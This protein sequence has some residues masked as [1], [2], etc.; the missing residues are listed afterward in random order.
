MRIYPAPHYT[1]GGLW[2]DYELMTTVP[3]LYSAGEANFS[4][5]GANRLGASA[6][7]QGLADGYFVLPAHD[8]QLPRPAARH[9]A[10]SDRPRRVQ[11]GR[12]GGQGPLRRLPGHRGHR[13][14]ST[15]S[16]ASWAASCGTTAAWSGRRTAWRRR[17][18]RSRPCTPSSDRTS[19]CRGV[20]A[21]TSR[22]RG[23]A[24]WTTSSSW[25]RSCAATP[26]SAT[27]AAAATSA[28]STRP[29]RARR[30][31]TTSASRTSRP[32]SG[33]AMPVLRPSTSSP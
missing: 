20:R 8:R 33:P 23:R 24:G 22:W 10:G 7:M 2:V 9:E 28:P 6:L 18:R 16:T 19:G 4:D 25:P 5:H 1:M 30:G 17:W 32:G 12:A 29:R 27:R 31:A 14:R 15:G 13:A 11:G 26:S 3:G 21:S